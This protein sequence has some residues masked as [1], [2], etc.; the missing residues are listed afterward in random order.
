[1]IDGVL[2]ASAP[3]LNEQEVGVVRVPVA[4]GVDWG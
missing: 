2:K 3:V 4:P 1:M